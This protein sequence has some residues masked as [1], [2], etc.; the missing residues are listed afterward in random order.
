MNDENAKPHGPKP[1]VKPRSISF[2]VLLGAALLV[3]I[4]TFSLLSPILL[5]L[6]LILL[7][8]L[9]VNPLI[10]RMRAL[11]GGRK[12]STVL[13]AAAFV[14]V[15]GLT[16]WAFIVPL[17]TAA[18]KIEEKLPS[19]LERLQNPLMKRAPQT[20]Q[21]PGKPPARA[22]PGIQ[23]VAAAAAVQEG[24]RQT[25]EQAPPKTAGESGSLLSNLSQ[26]LQGVA[27]GFKSMALNASQIIVV[28]ITVFFGVTFTLMNPRPIFGAIFSIVPERHHQQ[29]L[30]I[31][32]R[33]GKFL[34][35]WAFA[36]LLAMLTVGSLVFLLMWPFFGFL[37]ALVLGLIAGVFEAVPYLGPLL[38][39]VPALFFALGEGGMTPVWVLLVYLGVQLL[40]NNV[41]TPLI[42]AH[43]MKLHPVAVIFSM[44][45]C[46]EVFGVL[47]VLVAA[48]MVAIMEI[49]HDELYRKRFLPTVTDADLDRLARNALREKQSV[50][51]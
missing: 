4:E 27:S 31:L 41:I 51:K 42:M 34:P 11:T 14:L 43:G 1:E 44:L 49:L 9:A 2:Y 19:Y 26:M 15:I 8:S 45:L 50:G 40:E 10:S 47:G 35:T 39:A 21:R 18:A 46:V 13:V 7:I 5:S 28:C 12:V 37:D 6:L 22:T 16:A 3:F 23:P 24:A 30:T 17:K 32:Q 33:M 20:A 36:T 25:A 48:P 29:T 38:S